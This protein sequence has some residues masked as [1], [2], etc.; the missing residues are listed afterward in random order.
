M[1]AARSRGGMTAGSEFVITMQVPAVIRGAGTAFHPPGFSIRIFHFTTKF[2]K[3]IFAIVEGF[4]CLVS[5]F[6]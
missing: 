3:A 4:V 2:D 5:W 6:D 1:Q